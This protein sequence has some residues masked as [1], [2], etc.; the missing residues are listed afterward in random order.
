MFNLDP[1][2]DEYRSLTAYPIVRLMGQK[3]LSYKKY[4]FK[5]DPARI[6]IA[7][8]E[9][10]VGKDLG[11]Q[12]IE[13]IPNM[14]NVEVR[15][16]GD[17][18]EEPSWLAHR[19]QLTVYWTDLPKDVKDRRGVIRLIGKSTDGETLVEDSIV[20]VQYESFMELTPDKLEFS[21]IASISFSCH[22]EEW[23][24]KVE[25]EDKNYH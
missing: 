15:T 16:E 1:A 5:L 9:V 6:D 18:L 20:V 10:F 8:Q 22:G 24:L 2:K 14:E 3:L 19:N 13:V 11:Y 12:E 17:W 4:E 25:L 7:Q 21:E 23:D